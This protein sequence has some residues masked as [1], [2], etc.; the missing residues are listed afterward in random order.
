MGDSQTFNIDTKSLF[1]VKQGKQATKGQ[2]QI[3]EDNQ[4]TLKFYTQ[5]GLCSTIF[6]LSITFLLSKI[7]IFWTIFSV[8]IYVGSIY[9]MKYM[10]RPI[11]SGGTSAKNIVDGGIDLN[12]KAGFG[13]YLKDLIL[14]TAIC[15]V[16]SSFSNL[17]WI[18]W[19]FI[20]SY[21][22]YLIWINFIWPWIHQSA[23]EEPKEV[24]EKKKRKM[25]RNHH[26]K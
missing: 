18:L 17:F 24:S 5:V 14:A 9:A 13:D 2:R 20:P 7:S 23:E 6:N 16:L 8:L 12:M 21:F 10:A 19:L 22:S 15:Q 26:Y 25:A 4:S 11:F 1:A 3:Y